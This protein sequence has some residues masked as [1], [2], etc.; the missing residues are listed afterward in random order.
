MIFRRK[1]M[2]SHG[3]FRSFGCSQHLI[4]NP[5]I[6]VPKEIN[7]TNNHKESESK[8][9]VRWW[10]IFGFFGIPIIGLI[11]L[12]FLASLS[13]SIREY[14]GRQAM[15]QKLAELRSE[16]IAVDDQA[17]RDFYRS[18]T[19]PDR[20]SEWQ[21]LFRQI[22]SMEFSESSVGVPTLD[23][24]LQEPA[25]SSSEFD[26][27][28]NWPHAEACIRFSQQQQ[29]TIQLAR[30]LAKEPTPT[31]FPIDFQSI[32]TLLTEVQDCRTVARMLSVDSQVA[33]HLRDADRFQSD[34]TS[35]I[36]LSK[37]TDAVP[38]FV[39]GL[40]GIALRQI[41]L[42]NIRSAV[43]ADLL[44]A[45]Q[46]TELDSLI[47]EHTEIG[48]RLNE[49]CRGEM[50]IC[51]PVFANPSLATEGKQ[52][53]SALPARGRDAIYY[54]EKMKLFMELPTD[55]WQVLLMQCNQLESEIETENGNLLASFDRPMAAMMLP[56]LSAIATAVINDA[57]MHR[58][59]RVGIAIKQF[60]LAHARY[61]A[62]LVELPES[63]QS[64]TPYGDKPFGYQL[65]NSKPVLW[66]FRLS[67]TR[68]QTPASPP[69][70]EAQDAHSQADAETVWKF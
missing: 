6:T 28:T 46:L 33:L 32:N 7:L 10:L 9:A 26:V 5:T 69:T 68:K 23:S 48:D 39:S 57:Q 60:Q 12:V 42:R 58:Q 36:H 55:D 20:T 21:G 43:E 29:A 4:N 14:Y 37:H 45:S 49:L 31:Y 16:G 11:A 1:E 34:V 19:S 8:Q 63:I 27:S 2:H 3:Q 22:K 30:E 53:K 35:I 25:E 62:T 54:I 56:A 65:V 17:I 38:C 70:E 41:A 13:W 61:P 24:H 47:S 44:S 67:N 51:L 64:M 50:S 40:V 15:Q 52:Q 18:R 66:G 59:A